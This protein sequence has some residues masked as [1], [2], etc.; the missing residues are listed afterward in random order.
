MFEILTDLGTVS[1][2]WDSPRL[3][4]Y[5]FIVVY[6]GATTD[7]KGGGRNFTV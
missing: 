4:Q 6:K 7:F 3:I 5:Q 2:S 1:V